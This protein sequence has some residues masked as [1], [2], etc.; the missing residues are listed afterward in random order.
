MP[1]ASVGVAVVRA[2]QS[3]LDVHGESERVGQDLRCF[4]DAPPGCR[5][6]HVSRSFG[7]QPVGQ[8]P[9]LD[10]PAFG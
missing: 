5:V 6:E 8:P 9:D 3:R 1:W 4:L 10:A 7:G 2:A